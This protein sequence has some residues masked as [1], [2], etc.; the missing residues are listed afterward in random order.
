[1]AREIISLIENRRIVLGVSG[2]IAAYKAVDLASTLK[3]ASTVVD[4]VLTEAAERFVTRV[5]FEAVT[6]RPVYTSV[7][8][9]AAGGLP[10][11][12]AHVGL[13][14]SA[15]LLVV[16]PAT[17]NTIA[18]LAHGIAD[19]LLTITALASRCPML[20]A[21]A[22]DGEMYDHPATQANLKILQQRGVVV[23]EPET[24]HLASGL[25]GKGR[26]PGTPTL[27]GA[28]R[29]AFAKGGSLA[30]RRVVVTAGGTR[31][32]VDPVRYLSN[33][34]SGKQGYALA[35]AAI[36]AGA[37][38]TLVSSATGLA[39]P[40]G[41]DIVPVTSAV[42]MRDVVLTACQN[43]DVLIMAAAVADYRPA[44]VAR[45]K[46]KKSDDRNDGLMLEL[47]RNPDI[48]L[49]V[50]E[51]RERTGSPRLVVGFAAESEN[52]LANAAEKLARK[53]LDLIVA[54]DISAPDSGFGVDSNRATLID[55]EGGQQPVKLTS[56]TRLAELVIERVTEL[57]R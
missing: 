44:E 21:P 3:Q 22:M 5:T 51:L 11:H 28:I 53:G 25:V 7:W 41:A 32:A 29:L 12:I 8:K 33:Y 20:V 38:V 10:T 39:R 57:L 54:N 34:S 35:Q 37:S 4:V 47:V 23:V 43:A 27:L 1:M 2:S 42:E 50:K 48:L 14:E 45:Q 19:D 17:A 46:I 55:R 18:K 49:A 40:Y 6:G 16:A 56:K 36:D 13:G 15:E 9:P 52:L 31:E 30:G 24:G 26:L